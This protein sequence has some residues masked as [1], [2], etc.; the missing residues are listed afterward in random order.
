VN[1][2]RKWWDEIGSKIKPLP[3]HDMEEHAKRIALIAWQAHESRNY[4]KGDKDE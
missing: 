4:R 1:E 3:E 2:F